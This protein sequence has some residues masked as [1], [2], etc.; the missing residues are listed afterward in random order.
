[1][2]IMRKLYIFLFAIV[3]ICFT[4][5]NS[6]K[7]DSIEYP[8]MASFQKLTKPNLTISREKIL[9]YINKNCDKTSSLSSNAIRDFYKDGG[10]F[11]WI[12]QFTNNSHIDSLLY[13]LDNAYLQHAL[14]Q[15]IFYPSNIKSKI[16]KLRSLDIKKEDNINELLGDVEFTFSKAYLYYV[17]GL[18]YG[19]INPY[20][21]LN[22]LEDEES[23]TGQ[24]IKLADGKNKKKSL[25]TIQLK[26]WNKDL[27]LHALQAAGNDAN[28][29][30]KEVQPQNK[31]YKS[32][33][34]EFLRINKLGERKHISIPDIGSLLLEVGDTNKVVAYIAKNLQNFGELDSS[35]IT[36]NNILTQEIL[37]ATNRFRIKN[38]L[39]TDK[40][41]GSFTINYL[42][43]PL[44]YYKKRLEINMER[45]RWQNKLEKGDKYVMVNIAAFMLQAFDNDSILEMR[46]C[47]GS[48][49]NKTPLLTSKISY[50]E[51]NPYWNVPQSI[52]RKEIIPS[53]RRDTSYFRRNRMKVY[54]LQG[55]AV[56]PH[57]IKW[58]KYKGGVPFTVKQDNKQGNSL[59]RIIFRFPNEFAVYLHDTPSRWAFMK[60]NRGVSHGCVRLEKALDFAF[61]LLKDKDDVT[62]DRIR[63]AMDLQAETEDGK[64]NIAKPSYKE[65]KQY[66]L[67]ESI[68]LFLD[69]YTT[70][71]SKDGEL[72]YCDDIY[73][74]DEPLLE[75]L[76]NVKYN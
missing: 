21:I 52:I 42:N 46:I 31:F 4:A 74:Y 15:N 36:E 26:K 43:R 73:K 41:I 57:S 65:L 55:N 67:K 39:A 49:R 37:D 47:C 18:S 25:Y 60:V 22:D 69:Y 32:M 29:Y 12:D 1:M 54:D 75:A 7:Q 51:L 72:S 5:C 23:K 48:P 64:K 11:I 58:S 68:P 17:S 61:F 66:T 9:D 8:T 14:N 56:N 30:L 40:S 44:S 3:L 10:S 19:F 70:F 2:A 71:Y 16:K 6:K 28:T 45:L 34:N 24:A 50:M 76:H 62:M 27:A 33:Q 53:Y 59:G 63:V 35:Y 13:W 20:E 38:R